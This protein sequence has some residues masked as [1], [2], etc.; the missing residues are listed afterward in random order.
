ML[1]HYLHTALAARQHIDPAT[2]PPGTGPPAPGVHPEEFSRHAAAMDWFAAERPVLMS[3]LPVA[4]AAGLDGHV[5][6]LPVAM[7]GYLNL[8]GHWQDWEDALR[9]SLAAA[10]RRGDLAGQ[11][12]AELNI[13]NALTHLGRIGE[14][15]P[16]LEAAR[17]L[18][19]GLGHHEGQGSALYV[20]AIV[21]SEHRRFGQ[22]LD[23]GRQSLAA[24]REAGHRGGQAMA[25]RVIGWS[26][27]ELGQHEDAL[28]CCQQALDLTA[29]TGDR[30]VTARVKDVIGLINLNQGRYDQA[31]A[32]HLQ[33]LGECREL[34][35]R[36]GEADALARLGQAYLARGDTGRARQVW[37]EAIGILD[38]LCHP[39]AGDI[40]AR[41]RRLDQPQPQPQPQPGAA[42]RWP[43]LGRRGG[44]LA[45]NKSVQA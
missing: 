38:D 5:Q 29:Q 22:G 45:R 12:A 27:T 15:P 31:I 41:L 19:A 11:G 43:E 2:S 24:Y 44:P 7:A 40:R 28:A 39:D 16:H 23:L 18:F 6:H 20:M 14:A 25:L 10:Q 21:H 3:V 32:C 26:L 35:H 4:A 36:W 37:H 1:D 34:G 13:G 8:S 30:T 42:A 17:Q 9:T 33:S